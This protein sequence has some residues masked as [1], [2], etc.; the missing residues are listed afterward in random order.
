MSKLIWFDG[1]NYK[2]RVNFLCLNCGKK[3][4]LG[5]YSTYITKSYRIENFKAVRELKRLENLILNAKNSIEYERYKKYLELSFL[6][7]SL[8][9][10]SEWLFHSWCKKCRDDSLIQKEK[11]SVLA[12]KRAIENYSK[13]CSLC[14]LEKK[15]NFFYLD[16]NTRDNLSAKCKTCIKELSRIHYYIKKRIIEQDYCS[17]CNEKKK[18]DLSNIDGKYSKNISTWWWLCRECHQIFD[19]INNT[20]GKKKMNK[21]LLDFLIRHNLSEYY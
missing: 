9:R 12:K 5:H 13:I 10:E 16:K 11:I 1:L 3:H 17:I 19:I 15:G 7:D 8:N 6:D 2:L 18:L 14:N 21:H 20:H 4:H